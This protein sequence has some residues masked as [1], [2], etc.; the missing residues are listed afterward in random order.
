MGIGIQRDPGWTKT[1]ICD[2]DLIFTLLEIIVGEWCVNGIGVG[3]QLN[4]AKCTALGF[5]NGWNYCQ[6]LVV[7]LA[8][9]IPAAKAR[10][11]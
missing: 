7:R 1:V 9:I 5:M 10:P 8:A 6:S 4:G 2:T 3:D 11:H